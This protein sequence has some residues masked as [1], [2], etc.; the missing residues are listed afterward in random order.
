MQKFPAEWHLTPF[1]VESNLSHPIDLIHEGEMQLEYTL[2]KNF[3]AQ[4]NR[5]LEY[6]NYIYPEKSDPN[7]HRVSWY[8]TKL[9]GG[10]AP[11]LE[12]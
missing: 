7:H 9:S 12:L 8:D 11:V 10:E 4:L 2:L 6:T 1:S 5:A 3:I